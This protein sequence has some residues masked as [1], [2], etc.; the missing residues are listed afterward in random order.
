MGFPSSI[1]SYAGFISTH[2]LQADNHA[3]Q[4][5]QEQA[6]IIGLA[7]KVGIGTSTPTSNTVLRGN[8]T[9]TST[10][11][12]VHLG[13]DVSG[14][15]ATG[16]GGTG[17]TST[18]GS[19]SNVFNT[20]PS[21]TTPSISSPTTTN[22]TNSGGLTNTGG[23]TTDTLNS[24]G[25]ATIAGLLTP[26]GGVA[27][28]TISPAALLNGLVAQRQGGTT[29]NTSWQT[30]G[31][32]NTNTS[33]VNAFIQVGVGNIAGA[34]T[35]VTFPV[36]FNQ[37]PIV[38]GAPNTATGFNTSFRARNVTTTGF[39]AILIETTTSGTPPPDEN[40]GWMAVGQ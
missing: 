29:G 14:V 32:S 31:T 3:A 40:F 24:T 1:P 10:F 25:T 39:T 7:T 23:L 35:I 28:N 9:G 17:T 11:D 20:S 36:A 26:T 37:T 15:L 2:T 34:E 5:N 33:T 16:N 22:L 27:N 21:L 13:S 8:G 30:S 12:Q 6:D 4:H 19:G 18:T 38:L